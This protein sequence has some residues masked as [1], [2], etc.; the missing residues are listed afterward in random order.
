MKRII[1]IFLF[2]I[3]IF[4]LETFGG[5]RNAVVSIPPLQSLSKYIGGK[6]WNFSLI[7]PANTNPHIFEPT[8]QT[9]KLIEKADLIIINGGDIDLWVEN[10][11]KNKK[12][13]IFN[14]SYNIKFEENN[15]HIWLDPII[16]QKI[17]EN[18]YKKLVSIDSVNK[19]YYERNFKSLIKSLDDL[20]KEIKRRLSKYKRKEVIIY[21]PAWYYFFKRYDIETLAVVEEG[22]GREPSPK[23][24]IEVINLIKEK[25]IK[26]IFKEPFTTS[27]VLDMISKETKAKI[28]ILDP[29]GFGKDYFSMMRENLKIL[30]MVFDEQNR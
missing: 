13:N 24:I 10:L 20:D 8:P 14:I 12:K 19:K 18:I 2:F 22:E 26:Y 25:K 3:L 15:P 23:K 28:L 27:S 4:S 29:L 5:V 16:T 17:A 21:H 30:E 7:I 1:F 9:L 11:L 6:F